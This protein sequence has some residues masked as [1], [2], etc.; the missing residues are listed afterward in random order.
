M[1]FDSQGQSIIGTNGRL[2][3][4]EN[5]E[6]TRKLCML[7][8]GECEGI[9]PTHAAVKYG[10][11]RQRYTQLRAA[12]VEGGSAALSNKVSGPK[13]NYRR[14]DEAVRQVIRHR[15]LDPQATSEVIARKLR[16]TQF[17]IS[18]RSVERVSADYGLQKK[19]SIPV[20]RAVKPK[21]KRPASK[22]K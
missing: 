20:A 2:P 21:R 15:F 11:T 13:G 17:P 5:D 10:Y 18:T 8:E 22:R 14:T 16:Q 7:I 9:G 3:I 6:V 1:R 19:D 12:F 4:A